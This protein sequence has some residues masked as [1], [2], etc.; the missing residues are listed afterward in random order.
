MQG[1]LKN[2]SSFWKGPAKVILT[3]PPNSVWLA[4][5]GF[6]VKAS[7]EHL[8]IASAEEKMTLTGWTLSPPGSS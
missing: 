6:V 7:P 3:S 5:Q 1:A 4:Y 2:N 8:R